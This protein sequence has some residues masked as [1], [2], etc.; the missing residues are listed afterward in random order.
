MDDKTAAN[1][2]GALG[3]VTRLRIYRLLVRAGRDG[4]NVGALKSLTGSAASTL[5]HH[6]KA[7]TDAGLVT[8]ERR[9]REVLC[10]NNYRAM[11]ALQTFLNDD[12]C[13]GLRPRLARSD[14]ETPATDPGPLFTLNDRT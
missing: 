9:G 4:L 10:F 11:N 5:A 3:N 2:L 13:A 8:Q 12:C 7:L 1:A 14:T 6:L